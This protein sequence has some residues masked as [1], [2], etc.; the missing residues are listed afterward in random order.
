MR[1]L[2]YFKLISR[3]SKRHSFHNKMLVK[4]RCRQLQCSG[5]SCSRIASTDAR[6]T[7]RGYRQ[8]RPF[9]RP[10][11]LIRSLHVGQRLEPLFLSTDGRT[12]T[13]HPTLMIVE[14]NAIITT[15][16]SRSRSPAQGF[17]RR[18]DGMHHPSKR[19]PFNT[20]APGGVQ[21]VQPIRD[22]SLPPS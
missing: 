22:P 2:K 18:C 19:A 4:C 1:A 9:A 10:G 3:T 12:R 11:L 17:E 15:E 8:P 5:E 16:G 6:R 13:D 7:G 21:N 14:Y 20:A